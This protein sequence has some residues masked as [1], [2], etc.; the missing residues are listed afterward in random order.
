MGFVAKSPFS[1]EIGTKW[2]ST[3]PSGNELSL[4]A[5]KNVKTFFLRYL[6]KFRYTQMQRELTLI[7][8]SGQFGIYS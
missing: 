3:T 1:D 4:E 6:T 7:R 5:W 2:S 8:S